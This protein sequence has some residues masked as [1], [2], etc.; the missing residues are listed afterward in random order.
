[1]RYCFYSEYRDLK[2]GYTTL[3]ITLIRELHN[4]GK[5]VV[6]L[7]Y[8]NGLVARELRAEG[9][10]LSVVDREKLNKDNA[11]TFFYPSDIF[12]IPQ[13]YK[14]FN[15][16]MDVNP[17]II[18]YD[19]NDHITNI[20]HYK[21]I[22][23]PFLGKWFIKKLLSKKSLVFM[24][25]TGVNNLRN[26]F[27]INVEQPLFLPISVPPEKS[28]QYLI[29]KDSILNEI[30]V[31]YISRSVDWKMYPLKKILDDASHI[32][33]SLR[34]HILVDNKE[35][36]K[37]FIDISIYRTKGLSVEV[38]ENIAP[39]QI[40]KFLINHSDIYFGM[41][42][43]VLN[44]GALG[45]PTILMDYSFKSFPDN[46]RYNWLTKSQNFSL[47]RNIDK[48][49][50]SDGESLSTIFNQIKNFQKREELSKDVFHYVSSNHF[51]PNLIPSLVQY[52]DKSSFRLKDARRYFP[53]FYTSFSH[54][55]TMIPNAK[56]SSSIQ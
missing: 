20:S 40:S 56:R 43:T 37:R 44:A 13:F 50:L 23:F 9:I 42:T 10:E 17:R 28:N 11:D 3:I 12:I 14:F 32:N 15:A 2:G 6:L 34:F 47:G 52:C 46:Y 18:Y 22:Q 1:M 49:S 39:S 19:I 54:L 26:E 4:I 21:K 53:Y 27:H 48:F 5:E 24:D 29:T 38:Y 41:G 33:Q 51:A 8:K 45:I 30:N 31:S 16:L 35:L 55:S 25:D 7:N 36:F